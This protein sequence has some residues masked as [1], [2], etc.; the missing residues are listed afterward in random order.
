M[1]P[2][3]VRYMGLVEFLRCRWEPSMKFFN[4]HVQIALHNQLY[5][6][7]EEL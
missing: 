5:Y 6:S 7:Q 1:E 4:G 3:G 2:L